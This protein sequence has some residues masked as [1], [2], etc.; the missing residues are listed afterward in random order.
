[1]PRFKDYDYD[2][3]K[4]IP[5]SFD[6]QILP[7]TFESAL[8]V[9]VDEELDLSIFDHRY[10]NDETG[11]PAYDP[12]ILLKI[13]LLAYSRGITS[14][15]KI[16]Q[17]CRENVV[18][19][20][21][22]ADSQPHFTTLAEFI[23][24]SPEEIAQ[25]FQQVLLICDEAGLIGKEL[26]AIDGCKLPSNASK[27]WSGTKADLRKKQQKIDRAVRHILKKHR[28]TDR[29][30][31]PDE[32]REREQHQIQTLRKAS[33]KIK[34]FLAEHEDK[35]GAN[36]QPVQSNLTDNDSA[37]MKTSRGVIQGYN[38]VAAVDGKYQVVVHAEAFGQAQEHGLL[39]PMIEGATKNLLET[40]ATKTQ[41][42]RAKITADSG[43]HNEKALEYLEENTLDGYIADKGFRSRDPRFQTAE[44]HKSK[45]RLKPKAKFTVED[46]DYDLKN[47]TCM[48]PAGKPM[49]LKSAKAQ[50]GHHLFMQFQAHQGNCD[51]CPLRAH[52]LKRETQT[53][54]RQ[55]NIRLGITPQRKTG[56]IER[57]KRKID[58]ERGRHIYSQRLGTV[59]PVFGHIN[60]VIGIRRFSLR[61]KTKVDGQWKL[62]TLLHNMLKIYRYGW[63]YA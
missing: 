21:L 44:R 58:S 20:A 17:L 53:G 13:I 8:S 14:S 45:D 39:Q 63:D 35:L 32:I 6:R 60:D 59:E 25:L 34:R 28:E 2:Q 12:A 5:V 3:M 41:L 36:G 56:L 4:M 15:R 1:M 31:L 27:E 30:E 61:G 42:K 52:C 10:G 46:F 16:E 7:G 38:G 47:K 11:R 43:Y 18:F 23:S 54:A 33:R 24:S 19:M 22:S 26:F 48:C 51:T 40:G 55:V 49:W 50:I 37:K 62:M 9:L 57:M 29:R